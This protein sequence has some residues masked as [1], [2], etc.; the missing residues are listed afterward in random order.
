MVAESLQQKL[1]EEEVAM[2]VRFTGLS[3]DYRDPDKKFDRRK[4]FGV[5][6]KLFNI[7]DNDEDIDFSLAL[8]TAAGF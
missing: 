4:V 1:E 5:A 8:E 7:R 3:F 2:E 6:A